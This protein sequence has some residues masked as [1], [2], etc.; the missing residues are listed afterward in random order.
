[1][2]LL[3]LNSSDSIMLT[4]CSPRQTQPLSNCAIEQIIY[5]Q[6]SHWVNFGEKEKDLFGVETIQGH[7]NGDGIELKVGNFI[8]I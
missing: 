2:P 6:G 8:V 4:S 7:T 3:H 1:M 5:L